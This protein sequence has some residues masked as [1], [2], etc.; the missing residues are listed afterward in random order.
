M[1]STSD[2]VTHVIPDEELTGYH[3]DFASEHVR[4]ALAQCFIEKRYQTDLR[5]FLL[6]YEPSYSKFSVLWGQ[7]SEFYALSML[8][9]AN[10]F[11]RRNMSTGEPY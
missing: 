7:I 5:A 3:L 6:A 4:H 1:Q 8:A 2:C 10:T 9:A 11:K